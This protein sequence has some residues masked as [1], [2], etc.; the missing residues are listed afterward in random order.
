MSTI[1]EETNR[2][3]NAPLDE[4]GNTKKG[5]HWKNLT[6]YGLKAFMA[7]ALYMGLKVQPN[8]KTY[9]MR[10]SLFLC[11]IIS[12]IFT[13]ARFQ[14]LRRCLHLTNVEG[15]HKEDLGYYKIGQTRWLINCIRERCKLAWYLGKHLTV[16]GMMMRYKRTYSLI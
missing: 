16:D 12:N 13:R 8:L 14:G 2:Y 4:Q 15:I 7:L 11:P 3:A 9:W 1:V 6:I 10:D 5:P